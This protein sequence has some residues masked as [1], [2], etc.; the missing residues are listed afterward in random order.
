M[1]IPAANRIS[2]PAR[3]NEF[4]HAHGFATLVTFGKEGPWA[5]HLPFILDEED[6]GGRLRCHMAR[7]NEQWHH[8]DSHAEVLCIFL[9]PHAYISPSWY[10][11]K[12]AVPTWNYA[13]VH[14]YGRAKLEDDAFLRKT[15][16]DTTA[17]YE[18]KMAAPWRMPIPEDY[19]ASMMK[20]IVGF[21]IRIT[22]VEAKFKLGQNRSR[23]DQLGVLAGLERSDA[24]ESLSLARFTIAQSPVSS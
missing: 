11:A 17:K 7:A 6:G 3:I 22:R 16:E 12:V 2:D 8:F 20:A 1:Y 9:G 19:I 23:E 15:I 5:S 21:S 4:I 24:L 14:V 13:A 18:S 10:S